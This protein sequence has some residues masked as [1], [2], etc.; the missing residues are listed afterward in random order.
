MRGHTNAHAVDSSL[1]SNG[2]MGV[3]SCKGINNFGRKQ[4][5]MK[6]GGFAGFAK[7]DLFGMISIAIS[8]TMLIIYLTSAG[9]VKALTESITDINKTWLIGMVF[10]TLAF[11]L[12]EGLILH[13][14][15]RMKYTKHS[16]IKS[17]KT[18]MIGLLYNN[19]TPYGTGSQPMQVYDLMQDGIGAGDAASFITVKTLLYQT[20]L[21]VYAVIV[22]IFTFNF[23]M[24][25]IPKL[26]QLMWIGVGINS[27]FVG[28]TCIIAINKATAEKIALVLIKFFVKIRIIKNRNKIAAS[29]NKHIALFNESFILIYQR[30]DKLVLGFLLTFLQQTFFYCLPYC[31]YRSF[32]MHGGSFILILSAQAILSL[33][34]AFVP[35]P[36]GSG[37]A[38]SGFYLFFDLFFAQGVIMPAVFIWRFLTYYSTIIAG[39]TV[40]FFVSRKKRRN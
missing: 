39:G 20:C 19:L 35:I 28:A 22:L 13:I 10:C 29:L 32:N 5:L 33:I 37:V 18:T 3:Y 4:Y 23:F 25:R 2:C 24:E 21:T 12:T 30:K 8:L 17:L 7:K 31:I 34:M 16:F 15:I 26:A 11:W 6:N 40:S 27:L 36:G 38:E 1:T 9:G 14:Y